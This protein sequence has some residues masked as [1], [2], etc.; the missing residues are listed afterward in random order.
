MSARRPAELV[1]HPG[2]RDDGGRQHEAQPSHPVLLHH[3]RGIHGSGSGPEDCE[4]PGVCKG[5][6]AHHHHHPRKDITTYTGGMRLSGASVRLSLRQV[7]SNTQGFPA[8]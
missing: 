5:K 6:P 7:S 3:L 2:E 1:L 4:R 8:P